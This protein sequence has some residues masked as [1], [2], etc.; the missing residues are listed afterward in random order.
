MLNKGIF[1]K[2]G[3]ALEAVGIAPAPKRQPSQDLEKMFVCCPGCKKMIVEEEL[4]EKLMVCPKC[5]K[6]MHLS[7]RERILSIADA[8]SFSETDKGMLSTNFLDFPGYEKKLKGAIDTSRE[9]EGVVTGRMKIGGI[10]CAV[11]AMDHRFMMGSMGSVVGEKITRIFELALEEKL[12]V[13]GYTVSG[14]ARMHEGLTSLMQMAKVSGAVKR[15]S[16]AGG[17]YICVL[18]DPTSGGITASFA[19]EADILISEPDALIAFAGP[20]VIEQTIHRKLPPGFQR[21]EFLLEKGFLDI[22]VERKKQKAT[23]YK[24]LSLHGEGAKL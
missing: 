11:F 22:I 6:H 5:G 2:T 10:S 21:A 4:K 8:D 9:C 13:I 23:I 19:M 15:F 24:L 18:T 1:K 3:N 7:G 12:P 16:D 20:R 14:G 17:L